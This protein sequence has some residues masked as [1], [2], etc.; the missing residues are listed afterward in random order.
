[1]IPVKSLIPLLDLTN[2]NEQATEADIQLL[3]KKAQQEIPVAAVCIYP[4][5]ISLAKECL[6]NTNIAVAT[7]VN[8]PRGLDS[9]T[10]VLADIHLALRAGADEIDVVLN[11]QASPRDI[12][13]FLASCRAACPEPTKLKIILETGALTPRQIAQFSQFAI[14]ADVD[15]LKT[16]TGKIPVGATLEAAEMMLKAIRDS[17]KKTGFK[18]S[19]GIR[20]VEQ[21]MAYVNLAEDRMGQGWVVPQTFRLGASGLLDE[22]VRL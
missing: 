13:I 22:I 8:F 14:D 19:G 15:F 20:Q 3:C 5:F 21:A 7:V 6:M 1:M 12:Q 2:L 17:G 10:D 4:L 11:Y 18:A 16:S 9:L